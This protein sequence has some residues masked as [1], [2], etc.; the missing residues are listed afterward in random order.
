[1]R[2]TTT[3]SGCTYRSAWCRAITYDVGLRFVI[4]GSRLKC[5]GI[6]F[7]FWNSEFW[8]YKLGF[9]NSGMRVKGL[10]FRVRVWNLN[11]GFGF[12]V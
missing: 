5:E 11:F 8:T 4:C 12:R 2:C 1:V 7:R 10:G 3:P 6:G 9:E